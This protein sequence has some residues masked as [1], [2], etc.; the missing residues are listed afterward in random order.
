VG[1]ISRRL[2]FT[3]SNTIVRTYRH[4]I[5]LD[6]R[7]AKFKPNFWNKPTAEEAKL[8]IEGQKPHCEHPKHV[9]KHILTAMERKY[10][11][12]AEHET[13]IEEVRGP[14]HSS[15]HYYV[16]TSSDGRFLPRFGSLVVIV[17]SLDDTFLSPSAP[18]SLS[19]TT[20]VG[21]GSVEN[22]TPNTLARIP[23]RWMIR[24]CFKAKTGIMFVTDALRSAG[25]DP[26]SLY[27]TIQARPPPLPVGR[28][29]IQ[30]IPSRAEHRLAQV[31]RER[32]RDANSDTVPL[33]KDAPSHKTEE[34]CELTDALSPIYDQLSIKWWF[35]WILEILPVT[36]RFQVANGK[37]E[38]KTRWNL[39]EG[40]YIPKQ[41]KGVV[42]VHRSVKMRME[43]EYEDGS[44]YTPKASFARAIEHGNLIWVD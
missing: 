23:L 11:E 8:G 36:N 40:R 18:S 17:V 16:V 25:L 43:A 22:G 3:T 12:H 34:E 37:W 5:A 9:K 24:E 29:R 31:Q 2:P 1:L 32:E 21:G 10:S 44:K 38:K 28:A 4:A 26:A 33:L 42:K 39:G 20:D 14:C 7:R 6:E 30:T 35:W 13:D 27:P 19:S 41:K 15:F